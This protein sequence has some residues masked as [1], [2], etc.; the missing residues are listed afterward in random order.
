MT[1]I[2]L[3]TYAQAAGALAKA[4]WPALVIGFGI[5]CVIWSMVHVRRYGRNRPVMEDDCHR[6][7]Q[8]MIDNLSEGRDN[9]VA[10]QHLIGLI[11]VVLANICVAVGIDCSA[12]VAEIKVLAGK[13]TT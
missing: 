1:M 4:G 12:A 2:E 9:F 5:G 10:L 3:L 8:E 7:Q 6:C 11:G 13:I